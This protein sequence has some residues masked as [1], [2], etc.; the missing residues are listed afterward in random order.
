MPAS[1]NLSKVHIYPTETGIFNL[2]LSAPE[3]L[4]NHD[5]RLRDLY[6]FLCDIE[7][8]TNFL[9]SQSSTG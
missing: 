3:K 6:R 4:F 1:I 7:E 8:N 2:L 9:F 5:I